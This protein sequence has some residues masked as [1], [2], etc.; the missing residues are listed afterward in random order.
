MDARELDVEARERLRTKIM[1]MRDE[2]QRI[3]KRMNA[4]GWYTA[5]PMLCS[6]MAAERSMTAA[7]CMF[8]DPRAPAKAKEKPGKWEGYPKTLHYE[9]HS[10]K[11]G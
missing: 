6:I 9:A 3:L 1:G 5:D 11:T 2:L 4:L 8:P 10:T 7:L